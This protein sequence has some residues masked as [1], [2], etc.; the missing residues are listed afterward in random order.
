MRASGGLIR[1]HMGGRSSPVVF[2]LIRLGAKNRLTGQSIAMCKGYLIPEGSMPG[3]GTSMV[4]GQLK[5]M[6]VISV[7]VRNT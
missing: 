6:R 2:P 4:S 5:D 3:I 7:P 1:I